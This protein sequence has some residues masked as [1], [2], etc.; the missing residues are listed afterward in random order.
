[1][2]VGSDWDS[3]LA[4]HASGVTAA[5]LNFMMIQQWPAVLLR[6]ESTDP[7]LQ[8]CQAMVVIRTVNMTTV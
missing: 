7:G 5:N 3:P 2:T 4:I 1:M 6:L 8:H